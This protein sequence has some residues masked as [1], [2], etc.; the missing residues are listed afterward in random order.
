MKVVTFG[1]IMLRLASPGNYR[2]FQ[3]PLFEATFGGGEANVAVS[4][5]NYGIDARFVTKVPEHSIGQAAINSLRSLGVDTSCIVRGGERLGIY[6]LEKGASQ[7]ASDVIYDRKYSSIAMSCRTDF[8][9]EKIFDGVELFHFTGITPAMGGELLEICKDA[10]IEASKRNII[11]TC[12]LNYRKKMWSSEEANKAMA[13]LSQYIDVCIAN[14][15]DS[16]KVFGIKAEH[17]DVDQGSL[18]HE[19]YIE[20]AR[21]LVDKFKF[22][23]VAIALRESTSADDNK[24]AAMYYVHGKAYFSKEYDLHIVDR[25]GGG[26]SFAAGLIYGLLKEYEPQKTIDFAVAASALKHTIEGDFNRVS[27]REVEHLMYGDGSGRVQR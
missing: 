21:K 10:C 17:T 18:D 12:D 27:I 20:V 2:H 8:D 25:V 11:I 24:W 23:K 3:Q 14:E 9:W 6:Y 15:E 4:L 22:K 7:R 1:E 26:D 13:E 19:S 5:S 16:D